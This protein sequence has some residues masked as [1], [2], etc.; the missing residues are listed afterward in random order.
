VKSVRRP[1]WLVACGLV[2]VAFT[3]AR[4]F[5]GAGGEDLLDLARLDLR[6]PLDS[7]LLDM[8]D[9][10][11]TRIE[12]G[13]AAGESRELIVPLPPRALDETAPRIQVHPREGRAVFAGWVDRGERRSGWERHAARLRQRPRPPA[14]PGAV[15]ATLPSLALA[16][17]TAL[18]VVGLRSSPRSALLLACVLCCGSL[19]LVK[20]QGDREAS[21]VRVLEGLGNASGT[22]SQWLLA[23]SA[24]GP[25]SVDL[26]NCLRLEGTGPGRL[27]WQVALGE[28]GH[29]RR[30]QQDN[31]TLTAFSNLDPQTRSCG[32]ERNAWGTMDRVW[33]RGADGSWQFH[34]AWEMGQPL[35]GPSFASM[36][37]PA[38]G[39]PPGW[40][41]T[42]LPMGKT[43]LV[44]HLAE[45]AWAGPPWEVGE[46]VWLRWVAW[47]P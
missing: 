42:G 39:A 6:G 2:L 3:A 22:G 45:G 46:E 34:G 1:L 29:T 36:A 37:T 8:G 12:L 47:A 20:F 18:L 24:A 23:R 10:G 14:R 4:P 41:T 27:R 11:Q 40:L 26:E 30:A 28:W 32:P 21:P 38:P 13:L 16:L 19:W 17:A 33:T 9:A 15:R 35:P 7:I 43:V 44:A 25:L 31:G 5:P